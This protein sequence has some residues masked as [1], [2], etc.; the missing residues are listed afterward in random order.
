MATK[1]TA[2]RI[3]SIEIGAL[4]RQDGSPKVRVVLELDEAEYTRWRKAARY[5]PRP[6]EEAFAAWALR[7]LGLDQA[8]MNLDCDVNEGRDWTLKACEAAAKARRS[9]EA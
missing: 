9:V 5:A 6:E 8:G 7:E 3:M 1:A 4:R 2:Q